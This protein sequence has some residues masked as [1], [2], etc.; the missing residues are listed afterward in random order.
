MKILSP[1]IEIFKSRYP[2]VNMNCQTKVF[3]LL[4]CSYQTRHKIRNQEKVSGPSPLND[5]SISYSDI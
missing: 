2:I 1:E 3:L 5:D 4:H